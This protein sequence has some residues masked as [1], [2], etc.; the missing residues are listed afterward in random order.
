[1]NYRI[2][3]ILAL[4]SQTP[5]PQLAQKLVKPFQF[6]RTPLALPPPPVLTIQD[7]DM[8]VGPCDLGKLVRA[9]KAHLADDDRPPGVNIISLGLY[10]TPKERMEALRAE[11]SHCEPKKPEPR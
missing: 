7:S 6:D 2:A 1:M 11:L 3:V 10:I 4:L 9:V 8:P 5:T